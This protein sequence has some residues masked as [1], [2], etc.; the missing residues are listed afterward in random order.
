MKRV[1]PWAGA[2]KA[3]LTVG[4]ARESSSFVAEEHVV[5]AFPLKAA[6]VLG[7]EGTFRARAA[8]VQSAGDQLL[9]RAAFAPY[10][11]R[12]RLCLRRA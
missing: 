4:S 2:E 10:E 12:A 9:A 8:L 7:D 3:G 6:G 1:P 11:Y 5:C